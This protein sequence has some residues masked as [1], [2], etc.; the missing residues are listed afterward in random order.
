MIVP[1]V[2]YGELTSSTSL[3]TL[4]IVSC[5]YF[6]YSNGCVVI[7]LSLMGLLSMEISPL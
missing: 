2:I 4:E 3:P 7:E 6:S 1:R 5:F